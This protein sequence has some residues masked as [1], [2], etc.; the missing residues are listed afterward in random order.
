VTLGETDETHIIR[1]IE[2]WDREKRRWPQRQHFAVLVAESITRRFFNV[3]QLLSHCIPIIAVQANVV[4]INGTKAL[5]FAKVLD[6]YEEPSDGMDP[7]GNWDDNYWHEKSPWTLDSA[8]TLLAV[9][10]PIYAN[11]TLNLVKDYIGIQFNRN[12]HFSMRRRNGG[13]SL[14]SFWVSERLLPQVVEVLDAAGVP[15]VQ[16]REKV[17]ITVDQQMIQTHAEILTKIAEAVKKS[18]EE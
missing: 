17:F 11:A 1:T 3:I 7:P 6:T 13:K 9:V 18:W 10:Q 14:L 15:C 2:Y 8:K 16:K 5:H 12:N 4:E